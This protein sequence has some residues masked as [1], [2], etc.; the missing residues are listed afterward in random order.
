MNN[1]QK[2]RLAQ[3]ITYLGVSN[4]QFE[5]IANIGSS[6]S[7]K[8]NV[9][10]SKKSIASICSAFPTL[11]RKWLEDG[12]GDMLQ[13]PNQNAENIEIDNNDNV[14]INL[15]NSKIGLNMSNRDYME[16]IKGYQAQI[17]ELNRQIIEKDARIKQLTDKLLGL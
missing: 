8:M 1:P 16:I 17:K 2:E 14:G 7:T 3:F 15:S 10:L 9:G 12:T 13:N 4:S 5:R 6:T 11:N